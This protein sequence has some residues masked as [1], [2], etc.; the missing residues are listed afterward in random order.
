MI[1]KCSANYPS[2][3]SSTASTPFSVTASTSWPVRSLLSTSQP[4]YPPN[5]IQI[6]VEI[7]FG[8]VL[9]LVS[10]LSYTDKF[11]N[12]RD[13]VP[14]KTYAFCLNLGMMRRLQVRT[15]QISTVP[16]LKC[17]WKF[18]RKS[19]KPKPSFSTKHDS[20]E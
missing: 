10:I 8:V 19:I 11:K 13:F 2:P 3:S 17:S 6:I 4:T 14:V 5:P 12:L 20:R 9:G 7:F 16:E 1:P 18:L 15:W